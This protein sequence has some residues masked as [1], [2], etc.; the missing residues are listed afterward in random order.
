MQNM[1]TGSFTRR[2]EEIRIKK[3]SSSKMATQWLEWEA[4]ERVVRIRH[5]MNDTEKHMRRIPVDGLHGP[6]QT[7]FQSK[8]AD[9]MAITVTLTKESRFMKSGKD[10][11]QSYQSY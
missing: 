10:P 3:V 4:A 1:Q 9:S 6:S 8:A 5:Q 2:R 11:W 7:V